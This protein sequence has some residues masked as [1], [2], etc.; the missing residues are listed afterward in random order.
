M[1]RDRVE[2]PPGTCGM[3]VFIAAGEPSGDRQG[4]ALANEIR[5]LEPQAQIGGVG[6]HAMA[7]AGVRLLFDSAGWAAIGVGEALK[8]VPS[9]W[10]KHRA[11]WRHLLA[12]PPAA[13]VLIDFGAFNLRLA[14]AIRGRG[15]P[16]LYYFP[17][18]SWSREPPTGGLTDL[19][20]AIATP[21]PWSQQALSGGRAEVRWVGHPL[22]DQVRPA[23]AA[24][25][26]RERWQIAE[27]ERLV[28][29]AP[30]SRAQELRLLLPE[31]VAAAQILNRSLPALRFAVSAAPG[32]RQESLGRRFRR[33]GIEPIIVEG[34]NPDLLQLAE[35]ALVTSGT[36]TLELAILGAP[37]VVVYRISLAGCVQYAI[38]R[39]LYGPLRFIA[40]PNVIAQRAIV[41]ELIQER[42]RG[43]LIAAEARNLLEDRA[44]AQRMRRE[45]LAVAA[46]LGP[47]G[48]AR[49]AAEMTLALARGR[50][51][52][53]EPISFPACP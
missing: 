26:A 38:M 42:A 44:A 28:V 20:D 48:A 40:M 41:P 31:L 16:I 30:G 34:L 35:V 11:I 23:L 12:K 27:S 3:E 2:P 24:A 14:R 50:R 6:S 52:E 8:K 4:A 15:I 21:F 13:L 51:I 1:S 47:P 43:D 18:R 29:V 10:F 19:V 22:V 9:L 46:E 36:A 49:R 39:R 45:L 17:P 7:G 32:V 33:I 25:A 5:R 37:M 53:D